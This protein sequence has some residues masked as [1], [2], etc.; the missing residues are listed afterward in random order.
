MPRLETERVPANTPATPSPRT[1]RTSSGGT[2]DAIHEFVAV[3]KL[4]AVEQRRAADAA[5]DLAEL[6]LARLQLEMFPFDAV[7][8][9]LE[10]LIGCVERARVSRAAATVAWKEEHGLRALQS[11]P[12]VLVD[13]I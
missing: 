3:Q 5:E 13:V 6:K 8:E 11:R 1:S 2:V 12:A 9:D 10:K 4:T 7:P